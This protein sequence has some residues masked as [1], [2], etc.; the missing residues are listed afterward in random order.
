MIG[1]WCGVARTDQRLIVNALAAAEQRRTRCDV[2]NR[3]KHLAQRGGAPKHIAAA[4]NRPIAK[5][6]DAARSE[7]VAN[8]AACARARRQR[9]RI[10]VAAAVDSLRDATRPRLD[11]QRLAM[12]F[13]KEIDATELPPPRVGER[14]LL[15]WIVD[16][17]RFCATRRALQKCI[18]AARAVVVRRSMRARALRFAGALTWTNESRMSKVSTQSSSPS[19]AVQ[20]E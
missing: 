20:R 6:V 5:R 19:L 13:G 9:R 11:R 10:V 14:I 3:V 7:A 8:P 16:D 12:V 4:Q 2:E 18:D 17:E 15:D 1:R